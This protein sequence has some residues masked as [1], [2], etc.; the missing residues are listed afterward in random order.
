MSI[1]Y[2]N[3]FQIKCKNDEIFGIK[4]KIVRKILS[5]MLKVC[6]E[7]GWLSQVSIKKFG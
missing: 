2:L 6:I 5:E 3:I 1:L 7:S 4:K